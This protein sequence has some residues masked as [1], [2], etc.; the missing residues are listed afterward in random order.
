MEEITFSFFDRGKDVP[1]HIQAVVEK[2]EQEQGIRVHLESIPWSM[3]WA[4]M[5]E[6]ALYHT[7]PDVSEIGNTWAGDLT[8]MEAL[9]LF[10]ED[11]IESIAASFPEPDFELA[12]S[13][14]QT[15]QD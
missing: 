7:G 1:N 3:G 6:V 11:E 2:F 9:R 14:A 5:V 10:R 15:K 12:N 4:R 8:R 13:S